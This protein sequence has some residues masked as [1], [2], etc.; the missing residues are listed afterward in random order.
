MK[1]LIT[2]LTTQCNLHVEE[3]KNALDVFKSIPLAIKSFYHLHVLKIEHLDCLVLE[4]NE[5]SVR[6][7][8]LSLTVW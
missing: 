3:K 5:P 8:H 2:L 1:N 6:A 4:T 7:L